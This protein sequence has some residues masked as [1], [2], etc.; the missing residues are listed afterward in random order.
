[1]LTRSRTQRFHFQFVDFATEIA[2]LSHL[3]SFR[4]IQ[5]VHALSVAITSAAL[6]DFAW[7]ERPTMDYKSLVGELLFRVVRF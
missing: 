5:A 4:M 2:D 6:R 7:F 3:E 1:M